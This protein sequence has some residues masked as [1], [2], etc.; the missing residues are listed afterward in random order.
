MCQT[1][2]WLEH[3]K[4]YREMASVRKKDKEKNVKYVPE[5]EVVVRQSFLVPSFENSPFYTS[6]I[7]NYIQCIYWIYNTN[8]YAVCLYESMVDFYIIYGSSLWLP[9]IAVNGDL[10]SE[11]PADFEKKD[12]HFL[13]SASCR[14]YWLSYM[15]RESYSVIDSSGMFPRASRIGWEGHNKCILTLFK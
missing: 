12:A 1:I 10:N 4:H 14:I 3:E 2:N 8:L 13:K 5:F 15:V 6:H 11:T 7:L 9:F